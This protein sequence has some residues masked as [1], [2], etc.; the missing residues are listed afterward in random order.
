MCYESLIKYNRLQSATND[1][2]HLKNDYRL[3]PPLTL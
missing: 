3:H 2:T 1:T